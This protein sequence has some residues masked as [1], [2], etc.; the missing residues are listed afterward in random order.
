M[1]GKDHRLFPQ[2][3]IREAPPRGG[4]LGAAI[5]WN[6]EGSW[7]VLLEEE[8]QVRM[9]RGMIHSGSLGMMTAEEVQGQGMLETWEL[10]WRTGHGWLCCCS[11]AL[12]PGFEDNQEPLN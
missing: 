7:T 3:Q 8:Q 12:G 1:R 5:G 9:C 10:G 6:K 11:M 4:I 2:H